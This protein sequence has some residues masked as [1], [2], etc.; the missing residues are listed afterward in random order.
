M[1][2]Y[3]VVLALVA[4]APGVTVD[5]HQELVEGDLRVHQLEEQAAVTA[6]LLDD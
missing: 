1:I 5:P 2:F 6:L 4:D 3:E